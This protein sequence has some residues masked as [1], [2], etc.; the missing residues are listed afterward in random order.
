MATIDLETTSRKYLISIDREQMDSETF[1]AFFEQLRTEFLAQKMNT[2][3]NDL[4][5]LDEEI[6]QSWWQKNQSKILNKIQHS[7][8]KRIYPFF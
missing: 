7:Y 2:D 5:A 4:L 1:Y 6:K 8:P 3:E